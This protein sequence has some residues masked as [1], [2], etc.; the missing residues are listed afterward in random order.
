MA[1]IETL[2]EEQASGA[3]AELYAGVRAKFGYLPNFA[4]LYGWAPGVF[5]A[6]QTLNAEILAGMDLRRYELATWA[7]ARKLRC[8]YCSI[9]HGGILCDQ[10]YAADEVKAIATDHHTAGL[11]PVD[12]AVMDFA[13]RVAADPVGINSDDVA[14]LREHG[15]SDREI[16]QVTL[17]AAERCFISTVVDALGCEP[18]AV[19]RTSIEP[20]LLS[21]LIVGR[22]VA[23]E[24]VPALA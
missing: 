13:E 21:A 14:P 16:F 15:L 1:Y 22:P 10:F 9:G 4:R 17:A 5:T 3:V 8:S 2:S 18:D 23:A 20:E 7:A 12:V 24:P 6:W 11:D 19:Y